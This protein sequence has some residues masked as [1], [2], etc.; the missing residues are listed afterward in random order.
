MH[1][2]NLM[3]HTKSVLKGNEKGG[4]LRKSNIDGMNLIRVYHMDICIFISIKALLRI[5]SEC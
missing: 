5:Q 3:K 2:N 4:G 1:E